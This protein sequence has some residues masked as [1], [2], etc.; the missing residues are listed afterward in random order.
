[1]PPD[2]APTA[3]TPPPLVAG[4]VWLIGVP[5]AEFSPLEAATD[6]ATAERFA[7]HIQRYSLYSALIPRDHYGGDGNGNPETYQ[8]LFLRLT[9]REIMRP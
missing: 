8:A 5:G 2:P 9:G 7:E 4:R 3:S 1:M 6:P